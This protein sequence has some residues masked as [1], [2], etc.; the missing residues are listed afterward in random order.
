MCNYS[1]EEMV[2]IIASFYMK[3]TG[4]WKD[5][6]KDNRAELKFIKNG[7]AQIYDKTLKDIY[8]KNE[9][10]DRIVKNFME[11]VEKEVTEFFREKNNEC[12]E[13]KLL[14]WICNVY[15]VVDNELSRDFLSYIEN[16]IDNT[17]H[18]LKKQHS[19]RGWIYI[20]ECKKI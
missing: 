1:K 3:N 12:E 20:L 9:C 13:Y 5:V 6:G 17:K 18:I 11:G 19:N 15:N 14:E 8:V 10:G 4:C 7:H 2:K 16:K